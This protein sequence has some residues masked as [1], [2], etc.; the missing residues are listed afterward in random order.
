MYFLAKIRFEAEDDKGRIKKIRE[1][2]LIEAD[3]VGE[4]EQ[5]TTKAFGNG[6]S[7]CVI[8]CVQES[9]IVGIIEK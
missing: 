1:Q 5:I 4:A 9:K 8:E 7:P 6:I 2:H 3:T